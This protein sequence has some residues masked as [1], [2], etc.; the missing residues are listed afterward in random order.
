MIKQF[1]ICQFNWF[2]AHD[3]V[4]QTTVIG[5]CQQNQYERLAIYTDLFT[6]TNK[7]FNRHDVSQNDDQNLGKINLKKI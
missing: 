3:Q 4:F 5:Y 7:I 6:L 2:N 1:S